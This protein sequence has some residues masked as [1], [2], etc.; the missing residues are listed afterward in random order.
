MVSMASVS[1]TADLEIHFKK[2][3]KYCRVCAKVLQPKET[4]HSCCDN[5]ELLK[6]FNLDTKT[7]DEHVHPKRYCHKCH[8]IAKKVS[9]RAVVETAIV[10][11]QWATHGIECWVCRGKAG[12]PKKGTKNEG[13]QK[14]RV[15]R[16][17]PSQH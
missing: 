9:C 12:R 8:T 15:A 17:S 14:T 2:L 5:T 3:D 10:P 11:F 13:G 1:D 16:E 6:T 7:D 4:V